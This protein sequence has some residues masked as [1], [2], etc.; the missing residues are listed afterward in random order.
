M[1][2]DF[3]AEA[4]LLRQVLSTAAHDL[5]G[6]SSALALRA[7]VLAGGIPAAD[8]AALRGVA[9]EVRALGRQLRV[10]RGPVGDDALA[11]AGGRTL[12]EWLALVE[13]FGRPLLGR[14]GALAGS[15][16]D[17]AF[18][19]PAAAAQFHALLLVVLA[20]CRAVGDRRG[21]RAV[22]LDLRV[23]SLPP[24]VEVTLRVR[25]GAGDEPADREAGAR[26]LAHAAHLARE[27]GLAW[28]PTDGGDTVVVRAMA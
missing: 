7:D 25:W 8:E 17:G 2:Y 4:Q 21:A 18:G 22:Q 15:A 13:R 1:P 20:Y 19:G 3:E 5:G 12:A 24:A 26:W 28:E 16:G 27:G 23:L 9:A 6:L 10:L 14:G 11:P